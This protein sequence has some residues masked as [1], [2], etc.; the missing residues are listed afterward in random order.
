MERLRAS[1]AALWRSA[2]HE[3]SVSPGAFENDEVVS[4]S[5]LVAFNRFSRD[6]HDIVAAINSALPAGAARTTGSFVIFGNDR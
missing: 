5:R 3:M 1:A 6:D 2:P 4:G